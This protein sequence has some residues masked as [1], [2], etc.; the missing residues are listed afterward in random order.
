VN[1][2]PPYLFVQGL[3]FT[4]LLDRVLC[5][6]HLGGTR[7]VVEIVEHHVLARPIFDPAQD[8]THPWYYVFAVEAATIVG[9]R[10]T[11]DLLLRLFTNNIISTT[12]VFVLA[13]IA[14]HL[15]GA[16]ALFAGL[17]EA[18]KYYQ[19]AIKVRTEMRFRPELALTALELAELLLDHY[20]QE[21]P[22][23]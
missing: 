11:A 13:C 15:G 8:S 21:R 23:G 10:Q 20:L 14:R 2:P 3:P 19:Q 5:L 9:H 17:D 6:A 1:D 22:K 12:G 16:C 4:Y 18:R 7:E